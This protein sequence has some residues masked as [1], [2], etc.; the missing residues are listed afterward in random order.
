MTASR[1]DLAAGRPVT[2]APQDAAELSRGQVRGSALLLLGRLASMVLT[3][4]TQVVVVRTL[5]TTDFGAFAFALAITSACRTL[6][7]L[8]Q[9]KS[10]SRHLAMYDEQRD[11]GRLIGAAL[12]TGLT[13]LLTSLVVVS[14]VLLLR[15]QIGVTFLDSVDAVEVLV[16]LVFLA[17]VEAL[18]E[19]FVAMFAVFA[20]PTAIFFR[21]YLLTPALR[22]G[23]VVAVA[24][25]GGTAMQI[26]VGYVATSVLGIAL[27]VV[28]LWSVLGERGILR[29]L[30]RHQ[31]VLPFRDVFSFSLPLLS[32]ELV[33]LSTHVGS[34]LL[35]AY[36]WSAAEVADYRAVFPA[37][38]LNQ[39]VYA[40]FGLLF[41]PMAARLFARGDREGLRSRYWHSAMLLAVLSFPVCAMTVPFA[42]AT[43]VALFGERYADAAGLLAILGLG[44]YLNV[45]LGFNLLALQVVGRVRFLLGVNVLVAAGNLGL[46]LALVPARGATGVAVA[47][48]V[49]LLVQNALY[50]WGLRRALG[51][52]FLDRSC[53]RVYLVIVAALLLLTT[54][55]VLLDPGIVVALPVAGV[56]SL[57]LLALTRRQ[58]E[59][60]E[61]F[62]ELLRVPGLRRLLV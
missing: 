36:Y 38:R 20:K 39:F 11:H 1:E 40:G 18:D 51:T 25:T 21:R 28:L 54:C 9:S 17:P 14:G 55:Q 61:T 12:V 33:Y 22:F 48:A 44:Y 29:D 32:L 43:T 52:R 23:T 57:G 7:S 47:N 41:L 62:P 58:L 16:V 13:V 15:D 53:R 46:G 60:G 35:L 4:A 59:I 31:V 6:L 34:V 5:S 19:V 8:G 45:C 30:E 37:A 10:L 2:A 50:Q 49:T 3:V 56:V 26:A 27:Y 24:L 42:P